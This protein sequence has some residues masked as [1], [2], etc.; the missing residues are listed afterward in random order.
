[1]YYHCRQ[2]KYVE[3][4]KVYPAP[5]ETFDDD[6]FL[7]IYK[8]LGHYCGFCP[9]IW[10]SRSR[11]S[12][13]GHRNSNTLKKRKNVIAKRQES[14]TNND[15]VLF[16]FDIIR[17][18]PVSYNYW[19]MIMGSVADG[20]NFEKQNQKIEEYLNII[21]GYYKEDNE[22]PDFKELRDWVAS[23]CDLDVYL[24]DYV[25]KELD[26][27]VVPSLNLKSA[28]KIICQNEKQKKTLRKMG[29]IDDRIQ[30]KNLKKYTF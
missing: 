15:S 26:Q 23:G 10:L 5:I 30:I 20:E 24:R 12:I 7:N 3:Y 2:M 21:L 4:D 11:S 16:G 18:F 1:M 22:E 8:W 13:T 9:Q 6:W 17:G 25:F 19:E 27:V 29:F 14:K 28:K